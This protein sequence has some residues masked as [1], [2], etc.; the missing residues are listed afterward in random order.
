MNR[1]EFVVASLASAATMQ[2]KMMALAPSADLRV[3]VDATKVGE[4]VNPLLFGGYME[5]ATTRV[6]AEMLT[7]R[8][9]ARS[10]IDTAPPPPGFNAGRVQ[11]HCWKPLGPAAAVEMDNISPFVGDHSPRILLVPSEE[12]GTSRKEYGWA[13]ANRMLAESI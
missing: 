10:V 12:R 2:Q 11:L 1:R 9:F 7:D 13:K 5:P 3:T 6:W 8:K 4:A